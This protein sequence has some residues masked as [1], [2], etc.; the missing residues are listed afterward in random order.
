MRIQPIHYETTVNFSPPLHH[1]EVL[2]SY[3][4]L[5]KTELSGYL[6]NEM[7]LAFFVTNNPFRYN[8]FAKKF[9]HFVMNNEGLLP[10]GDGETFLGNCQQYITS[11][12]GGFNGTEEPDNMS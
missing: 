5:K 4:A 2:R 12:F 1:I 8:E 11:E 10:L 6:A 9:V 7:L 3:F